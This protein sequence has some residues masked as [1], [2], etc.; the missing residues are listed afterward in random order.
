MNSLFVWLELWCSVC[1]VSFLLELVLLVM[2]MVVCVGLIWWILLCICCMIVLLLNRLIDGGFICV[3]RNLCVMC[4]W[5]CFSMCVIVSFSM[6]MLKGCVRKFCV[7]SFIVW[8][9]VFMEFCVV[10][11]MMGCFYWCLCI[12][13]SR[14]KLLSIG[15]C[16]LVSIR[17]MGLFLSMVSVC[18]LLVVRWI[19]WL[20]WFSMILR[21]CCMG[22]LL[23]MIRMEDG[24]M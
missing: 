20:S 24:F 5:C 16:R 18:C 12:E 3:C 19:W 1:V 23:L 8:M 4:R 17:L 7:F 21:I 15:M 13:C 22:V 6:F 10:I 14:L 2:N 9:V 11:M